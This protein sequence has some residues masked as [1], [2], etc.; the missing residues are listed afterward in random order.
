M[1]G[2]EYGVQLLYRVDRKVDG[3]TGKYEREWDISGELHE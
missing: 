3:E 1:I 2:T